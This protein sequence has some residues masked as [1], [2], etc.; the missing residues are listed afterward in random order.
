M[1]EVKHYICEICGTEY[2]EKSKAQN[3]ERGH[4]APVEIKKAKYINIKDNQKG[5]PISIDVRM[6]DGEIVTYKR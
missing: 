1:K 3:C 6:A 2:N 5:Y 4:V